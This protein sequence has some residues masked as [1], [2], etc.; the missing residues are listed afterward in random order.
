MLNLIAMVLAYAPAKVGTVS[1]RKNGVYKKTKHGWERQPMSKHGIKK[2]KAKEGRKAMHKSS[3]DRS[4]KAARSASKSIR[5][6]LKT[7]NWK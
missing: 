4:K 5:Q 6:A 2:K 1:V 3:R 7:G